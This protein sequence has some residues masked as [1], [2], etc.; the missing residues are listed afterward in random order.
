LSVK[1]GTDKWFK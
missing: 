1:S